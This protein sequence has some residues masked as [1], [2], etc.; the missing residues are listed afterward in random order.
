MV[1]AGLPSMHRLETCKVATD[2]CLL[3]PFFPFKVLTPH[4]ALEPHR[5][6][7]SLEQPVLRG[8]QVSGQQGWHGVA[9]SNSSFPARSLL[10]KVDVLRMSGTPGARTRWRRWSN[11]LCTAQPAHHFCRVAHRAAGNEKRVSG[12]GPGVVF[13]KVSRTSSAR[14]QRNTLDASPI[15]HGPRPAAGR[16]GHSLC[17]SKARS[18]SAGSCRAR[19]P[20]CSVSDSPARR[21]AS[22][23]DAHRP[24][25]TFVEHGAEVTQVLAA[26]H[27]EITRSQLPSNCMLREGYDNR[28]GAPT[29]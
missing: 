4:S 8:R 28:P 1:S 5:Q 10:F 25:R 21:R 13:M 27:N 18:R 7:N 3:L 9:L 22:S 6:S 16:Q 24:C 14:R 20:P 23:S 19:N 12:V 29:L 17:Q 2:C 26:T 15:V 11:K